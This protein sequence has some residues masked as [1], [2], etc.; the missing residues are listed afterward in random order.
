MRGK[1]I[2]VHRDRSARARSLKVAD[3]TERGVVTISQ[4]RVTPVK[5]AAAFEGDSVDVNCKLAI[6]GAEEV[7]LFGTK[8]LKW[9]DGVVNEKN[10][11]QARSCRNLELCSCLVDLVAHVPADRARADA[12][13]IEALHGF[14]L[15]DFDGNCRYTK[16]DAVVGCLARTFGKALPVQLV[17]P[18]KTLEQ[19]FGFG[20]AHFKF[21]GSLNMLPNYKSVSKWSITPPSY[22]GHAPCIAAILLSE[23]HLHESCRQI[24]P[25]SPVAFSP[26]P[27][28]RPHDL[29]T[30]SPLTQP[31]ALAG[32]GIS[33]C[34]RSDPKPLQAFTFFDSRLIGFLPAAFSFAFNADSSFVLSA[35]HFCSDASS[36]PLSLV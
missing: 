18:A 20:F 26:S 16:L 33:R 6:H 9:V 10:C 17:L 3:T 13:W 29:P 8:K 28:W 2:F 14:D 34:P 1:H 25:P 12:T 5:W 23:S 15:L 35:L 30:W 32:V 19:F 22:L 31:R 21:A 4:A 36:K 11:R 24:L 7:V 27:R